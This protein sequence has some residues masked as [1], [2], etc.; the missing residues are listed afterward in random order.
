MKWHVAGAGVGG[1]NRW[2]EWRPSSE[3]FS[4]LA[5]LRWTI[6]VKSPPPRGAFNHAVGGNEHGDCVGC[7]IIVAEPRH[8]AARAATQMER[9]PSLSHPGFHR[10]PCSGRL[11]PY[12]P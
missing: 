1:W 5:Q 8:R 6:R 9:N 12:N 2:G 10:I 3:G 4:N 7:R 11:H